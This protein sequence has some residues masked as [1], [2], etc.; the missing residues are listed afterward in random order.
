MK[1]KWGNN[2]ESITFSVTGDDCARRDEKRFLAVLE[3]QVC[4]RSIFTTAVKHAM[5]NISRELDKSRRELKSLKEQS[6]W[7]WTKRLFS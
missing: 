7:G 2:N 3:K 4:D 1:V 6:I 5:A